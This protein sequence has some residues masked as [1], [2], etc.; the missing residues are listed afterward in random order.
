MNTPQSS[1][2]PAACEPFVVRCPDNANEVPELRQHCWFNKSEHIVETKTG[3]ER[4][5]I[6]MCR[7]CGKTVPLKPEPF[8]P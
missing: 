4:R 2:I 6:R 1:T 8:H 3:Y 5:V 7:Y